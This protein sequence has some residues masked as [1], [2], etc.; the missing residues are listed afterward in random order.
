M[1]L[2]L[3][4]LFPCLGKLVKLTIC[5]V[6]Y[7][8]SQCMPAVVLQRIDGMVDRDHAHRDRILTLSIK[9]YRS[10]K[11]NIIEQSNYYT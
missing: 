11:W 5:R 1:M 7:D 3:I 4:L 8:P 2:A 9:I 6:H 10:N